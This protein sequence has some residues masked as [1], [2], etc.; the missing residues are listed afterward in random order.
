M[1]WENLIVEYLAQ[2]LLKKQRPNPKA[3]VKL[4]KRARKDLKTAQANLEIDAEVAYTIAYLAML[5]V[6]R[7]LLLVKGFRPAD[8]YQ[9]KTVVE[10]ISGYLGND[11][12]SIATYFDRMRRKRNRFTY[13]VDTSIS[14]T[15][16]RNALRVATEFVDLLEKRIKME[17]P[18][19]QL[20]F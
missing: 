17:H 1:T 15:E 10:F 11:F 20:E 16:A 3:V 8:R 14:I 13:E 18:Q 4:V 19:A 9:H 7:A 12:K 5:R 2:G 6:R